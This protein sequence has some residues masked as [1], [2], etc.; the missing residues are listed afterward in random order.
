MQQVSRS[1][2]SL[3]LKD[4][5]RRGCPTRHFHSSLNGHR[6]APTFGFSE[7]R[8]CDCGAHAHI[9]L[10]LC[11]QCPRVDAETAAAP[12]YIPGSSARGSTSSTSVPA[13]ASVHAHRVI[14]THIGHPN[15]GD[16]PSPK[17]SPCSGSG[18]GL[19][20]V[21]ATFIVCYSFFSYTP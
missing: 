13:L 10:R 15:G 4:V 18:V 2:S 17:V 12:F 9:S 3:R 6:V 8:C 19:S 16:G 14:R 7:S 5:P 11:F 1:P 20:T 21:S